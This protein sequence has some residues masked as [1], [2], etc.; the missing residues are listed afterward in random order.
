MSTN[1]KLYNVEK[2]DL[3]Q[4]KSKEEK[5]ML[6]DQIAKMAMERGIKPA[7]RY[8]NTY[9]PTVRNHLKK[10]QEEQKKKDDKNV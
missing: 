6:H 3:Y 9:P 8:F 4:N 1:F 2:Q 5:E 7:A 10:Y